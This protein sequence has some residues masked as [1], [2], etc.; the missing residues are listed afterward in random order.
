MIAA[1][2]LADGDASGAVERLSVLGVDNVPL[3]VQELTERYITNSRDIEDIRHL[4]ALADGLGRLTP[5]MEPYVREQSQE[6]GG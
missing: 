6:L 4:V 1:G 2:Y 3:Y 5:I